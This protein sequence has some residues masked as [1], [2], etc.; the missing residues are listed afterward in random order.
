MD[1]Q[2]LAAQIFDDTTRIRNYSEQL[3]SLVRK[4][5]STRKIDKYDYERFINILTCL[6]LQTESVKSDLVSL[7]NREKPRKIHFDVK[8]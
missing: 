7:I 1:N 3:L 6:N 4:Q 5:F 2:M 8:V